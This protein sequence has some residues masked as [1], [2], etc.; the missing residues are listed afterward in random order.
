MLEAKRAF[1]HICFDERTESHIPIVSNEYLAQCLGE[2]VV[3]WK[4]NREFLKN[5]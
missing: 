5:E 1:K 3:A 4:G 2:A